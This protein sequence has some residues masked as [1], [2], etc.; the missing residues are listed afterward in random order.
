MKNTFFSAQN[1]ALFAN[2]LDVLA[3]ALLLALAFMF[4][5]VFK[6]IPC[7]LCLLQ[8]AGFLITATG[9]LLNLRYDFRPSHYA[10][11]QLGALFTSFVALRQ[12]AL[13]VV[14]GTGTYGSSI[15]GLHM[16]T[17]SFI[18]ATLILLL[19]TVILGLEK[20]YQKPA[21]KRL[22]GW[23]SHVLFALILSLSLTNFFSVLAECGFS[24]CPDN[25][26]HYLLSYISKTVLF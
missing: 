19:T 17:W 3:I 13:H 18:A 6:E 10:L 25:P 8:R 21:E 20:Q 1:F 26:Q 2:L 5:F 9:F 14:P 15:F 4:Q 7:P 16:Y 12:I 11:S 23:V 24:A 22:F